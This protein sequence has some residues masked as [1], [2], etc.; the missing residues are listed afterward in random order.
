MLYIKIPKP[1]RE[2]VERRYSGA[3]LA[4]SLVGH[5]LH[6]TVKNPFQVPMKGKAAEKEDNNRK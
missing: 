2:N 3:P 6:R 5:P 1:I 4:V